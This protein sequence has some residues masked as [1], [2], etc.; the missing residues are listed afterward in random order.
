MHPIGISVL[1]TGLFAGFISI[2]LTPIIIRVAHN[3]GWYDD[4]NDPRKIHNGRVPRLGGVAMFWAFI[5]AT[6]AASFAGVG[7]MTQSPWGRV[8]LPFTLS[9]TLMHAVGLVDDF[10]D[11]KARIKFILQ[12]LVAIL[13]ITLDFRFRVL[14]LPGIFVDLGWVSYPLTYLWI[15]GIMN[16]VNMIDGLDG[17]AGGISIIAAFAY[18]VI[19]AKLGL[20][21][22]ALAAFAL[23]GAISGFLVFNFPKAK[24]FMGDS[25]SLFL[26]FL[27]AVLPLLHKS[28]F[29]AQAGILPAITVLLI[30]IYDVFAAILRRLRRKTS[31]MTPDREHLHHKLLDLGYDNRQ[32]LGFLYGSC[33]FLAGVSLGGLYLPATVQFWIILAVWALGVGAFWYVH[34][35]W[36]RYLRAGGTA[37]AGAET[38]AAKTAS[39]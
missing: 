11:V 35:R 15:V 27:L 18:G 36:H 24:I 1:A 30:P 22:P 6:S 25:G 29:P 37:G 26:G 31:I 21:F 13:V 34:N 23:V 16:A 39:E 12:S 3:R 7:D 32:I 9:L 19:Y 5:I 33:I 17:L 10:R 8:Y 14:P 28:A 38:M 2:C 20:L 4:Q